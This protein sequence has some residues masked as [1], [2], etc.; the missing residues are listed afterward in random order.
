MAATSGSGA[1]RVASRVAIADASAS[2]R[3]LRRDSTLGL[4]RGAIGDAV[5]PAAQGVA[6]ADRAG[7][8][9]QHQEGG[10]EGV[11]DV[12]LVLQHGAAGGQDHRAVAGD[13]GLEGGLVAG[14]RRNGPGA[15][16]RRGRRPCRRGT[17]RGG[18]ARSLPVRRWPWIDPLSGPVRPAGPSRA[19][20]PLRLIS[21]QDKRGRLGAGL[22]TFWKKAGDPGRWRWRS[23]ARRQ[24]PDGCEA[25]ARIGVPDPGAATPDGP[26]PSLHRAPERPGGASGTKR[27]GGPAR[28]SPMLMAPFGPIR[29][30]PEQPA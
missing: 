2:R 28:A 26:G 16:R 29:S 30:R 24:N 13:Q 6:G 17:G 23:V 22:P 19:G 10:L 21:L 8:P 7:L 14:V 11:L 12:V 20:F 27:T 25:R 1:G 9:G 4:D 18:A 15:G 3:R 5:Q